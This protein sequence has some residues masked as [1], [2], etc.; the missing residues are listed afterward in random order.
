MKKLLLILLLLPAPLALAQNDKAP[1][2]PLADI[3]RQLKNPQEMFTLIVEFDLKEGHEKEF[4]QLVQEAVRQTRKEGGSAA[5]EAHQDANDPTRFVFFEKWRSMT[6][7][8]EHV[9]KG[10]TQHLLNSAAE[11]SEKPMTVRVLTPYVPKGG[12]HPHKPKDP[13]LPTTRPPTDDSATKA[14]EAGKD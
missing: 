1:D 3:R 14:Q 6:A 7:L 13:N 9:M 2:D 5:Y 11:F 10:Y 8:E 4:R 12:K